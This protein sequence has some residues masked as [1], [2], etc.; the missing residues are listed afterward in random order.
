MKTPNQEAPQKSQAMCISIFIL[1]MPCSVCFY[2][3]HKST[4]DL[5]NPTRYCQTFRNLRPT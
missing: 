1:Y 5:C 2:G 3:I 4:L